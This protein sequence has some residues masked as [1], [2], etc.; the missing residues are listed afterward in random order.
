M[1]NNSALDAAIEAAS[2]GTT[3]TAGIKPQIE[4]PTPEAYSPATTNQVGYGVADTGPDMDMD[5]IA[6][7]ADTIEKWLKVEAGGL[8]VDD[9]IYPEVKVVAKLTKASEGGSL[10]PFTGLNYG[11]N[12]NPFYSRTF[13]GRT[14]S[15]G[16]NVGKDWNTHVRDVCSQYPDSKP[17]TGFKLAFVVAEDAV[18]IKASDPVLPA[19]T[20]IG[21][22][23]SKTSAKAVATAWTKAQNAK[24]VGTERIWVLS[25]KSNTA[26]NRKTGKP[27]KWNTLTIVDG[28][29]YVAADD[30]P[31]VGE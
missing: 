23:T 28:G 20:I 2:A 7:G 8:Q 12:D 10:K 3:D 24:H 1:T 31:D 5:N 14:V 16:E 27:M 19:G 26:N 25:G 13:N 4:S 11:T 18:G 6:L 22:T 21:Y 17:F 30:M 9:F 15:E 29:P